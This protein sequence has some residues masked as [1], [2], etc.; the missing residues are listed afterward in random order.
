MHSHTLLLLCHKKGPPSPAVP[1]QRR[2]G[3]HNSRVSFSAHGN[4]NV[5]AQ[6]RPCLGS[7]CWQ[8][9]S[10]WV[11]EKGLGFS[12]PYLLNWG[13][14]TGKIVYSQEQKQLSAAASTWSR[15]IAAESPV[16]PTILAL[17]ER[18]WW[19]LKNFHTDLGETRLPCPFSFCEMDFCK[20]YS[21]GGLI[22][23]LEVWSPA[24]NS[25]A[26][27][28]HTKGDTILNCIEPSKY[29]KGFLK[30]T[31]PAGY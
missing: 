18:E 11:T 12:T 28:A 24:L 26:K 5:P 30:I 25:D 3:F 9:C 27:L 29:V 20:T 22:W 31:W 15:I 13:Y 6:A 1:R 2:K 14:S 21:L 19:F 8:Q 10:K 23:H 7:H 17:S 16:F 4:A